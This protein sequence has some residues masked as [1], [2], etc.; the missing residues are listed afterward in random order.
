MQRLKAALATVSLVATVGA[1]FTVSSTMGSVA[2]AQEIPGAAEP[3][4]TNETPKALE[5]IDIKENLGQ[6]IDL[7]LKFHDETGAL[8]PL[9]SYFP[10]DRPVILTLA[11]FNCP[12]LC[13]FHLNGLTQVFKKLNWTV[14][15]EFNMVVLSFDPR[16][17]PDLAAA[18]KASYLRLYGRGDK[19]DGYRFLTGDEATV[20]Q[21]AQQVGFN[22]HW[23]AATNQF[24]HAS[25]AYILTPDG[26][27]SKYMYGIDFDPRTVRL[28]LVEASEG[29]IGTIADRVIL[30]CFHYDPKQSKYA[31]AAIRIM[32]L[33][34][35]LMIIVLAAFLFPYW[36]RQRKLARGA[37]ENG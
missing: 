11:Y 16:E 21:L 22:Y 6:A 19:N 1:V 25:A 36:R 31:I 2:R 5:S 17:K 26:H 23:D 27:I 33:G 12:G 7:N 30:Y 20:K 4:D 10:G 13:S 28:A 15:K 9:K 18:K 24:A 37:P 3:G 35:V 8:V 34:A 32:R 14:G 29:T